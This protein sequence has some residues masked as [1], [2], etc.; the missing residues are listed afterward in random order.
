MSLRFRKWSGLPHRSK[1]SLGITA[2][3]IAFVLSERLFRR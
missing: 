3:C 1:L 2:V